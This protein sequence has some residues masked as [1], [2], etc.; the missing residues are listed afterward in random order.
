MVCEGATC[1]GVAELPARQLKAAAERC[2]Q[3]RKEG[4]LHRWS[5][6]HSTRVCF[7]RRAQLVGWLWSCESGA[8]HSL[9]LVAP[10]LVPVRWSVAAEASRAPRGLAERATCRTVATRAR[11]ACEPHEAP[12]M[13]DNGTGMNAM[14]WILFM[15]GLFGWAN[16]LKRSSIAQSA[17]R[18]NCTALLS[19]HTSKDEDQHKLVR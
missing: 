17:A 18:E 4:S 14:R 2:D 5:E 12:D 16:W 9:C 13:R 7:F 15:V 11:Q 6:L 19:A 8:V 10:R 1:R 3:R